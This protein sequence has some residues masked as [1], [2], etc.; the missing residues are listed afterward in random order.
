MTSFERSPFGQRR[1]L[2][3]KPTSARALAAVMVVVVATLLTAC[4][5]AGA[6]APDTLATA[7]GDAAHP[8]D[9]LPQ[10]LSLEVP[11]S[12]RVE[13]ALE[14]LEEGLELWRDGDEVRGARMVDDALA[15]LPTTADWRPLIRA[16]L[17]APAGDTA[18]VRAAL[19][20]L[21]PG[22][23]F[24][25][26][27]GW[28][29]LV[30]AHE[31]AGDTTGARAAAEA[32]ARD[33]ATPD[34]GG[35]GW[36]RAGRLALADADTAGAIRH[37]EEA[38]GG[39]GPE[40]AS[41]R[42]AARILD[43]LT[44]PADLAHRRDVGL[45]LLAAGDWSRAHRHLASVL[46][47][48]A[49]ELQE[50]EHWEIRIG[51]GRTLL[52]LN[53]AR[54]AEQTLAPLAE[55]ELPAE[56][57]AR[58][59]YWIG[60]AALDRGRTDEATRIF[61]RIAD[62][63]P[64]SSLAEAG[65]LRVLQEAGSRGRSED[66]RE[67]VMDGL[68]RAGVSTASGEL[69]AVRFG[70][71]KYLDGDY[72][73]AASVFERYLEAGRRGASRQQAAYWAALAHERGGDRERSRQLLHETHRENPLS[74]YGT[75]AGE[76][77][78]APVLPADLPAGPSPVPGMGREIQ[79]ALIRLRVHQRVPTVGSFAH[80]LARLEAHF[81]ARGDAAYDF[82]EALIEGDM[83]IQ[84][85]VLGRTIHRTEGEWNLRLLRIVHPFP[86]R[87][88]IVREARARG[89][90][91]FF[92]AGLIRQESMFHPSIRSAA[93]AV[94]LMQLMPGTAR[95]VARSEGIRYSPAALAD[96]ATNVRLGTA[97]LASM[98]QRYGGRAEDALSAYN[99]GPT[100]I[101]QWRTRPE[102]RDT[103]VFLEHI[104]FQETR[105]YVKVV[106][107]YT[108][109]YTALYGCGEFAACPG[110]SYQAAVA[111]SSLAGGAPS[112]S[113]AR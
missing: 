12:A 70:T 83:P 15:R 110:L 106:Q 81:L 46:L 87:E 53:R 56:V 86:Y 112:S 55:A 113:L 22:T 51:L 10:L 57:A 11:D 107:Q 68:F 20:E 58:A 69:A 28:E 42:R 77:L 6:R 45:A 111:R 100:R 72:A 7:A 98:V 109:I 101:N 97:F 13:E 39:A 88:H 63:A 30:E 32:A 16:E 108:R 25:S 26:R 37:L 104:P 89:L 4:S 60:R 92:V 82:A 59:L 31:E 27:W 99:A 50:E 85:I 35:A 38:I 29:F 18:G 67:R 43:D 90:D 47:L 79:N 40:T 65:L 1:S 91:P 94:G 17:L 52:E 14:E 95:E 71:E 34:D 78:E 8:S 19:E 33:R 75:F 49:T 80:E 9:P 41:A 62:E 23:N 3:G 74:F 93:G 36:L 24:R 105:H 102:Y 84:G 2:R 76:R 48:E 5:E 73:R 54:E 66:V 21:D 96:P 44:V 103:Q 61:L 64:E